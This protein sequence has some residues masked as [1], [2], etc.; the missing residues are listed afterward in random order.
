MNLHSGYFPPHGYR[1]KAM[2][3]AY[4]FPLTQS[5][6]NQSASSLQ[7]ARSS[8]ESRQGNDLFLPSIST[9]SVHD[10][11]RPYHRNDFAN[12]H[13]FLAK[14]KLAGILLEQ[15]TR[16]LQAT[17]EL[18]HLFDSPES[19]RRKPRLHKHRQQVDLKVSIEFIFYSFSSEW[20]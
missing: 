14:R 11:R 10:S 17:S 7:S 20:R 1:R 16:N 18:I 12:N 4:H 8:L 15:P 2:N 19:R 6:P 3:N 5:I 13:L 9:A